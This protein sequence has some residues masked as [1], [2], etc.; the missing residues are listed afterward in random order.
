MTTPVAAVSP[1]SCF[2]S[3]D[4]KRKKK[5]SGAGRRINAEGTMWWIDPARRSVRME[6]AAHAAELERWKAGG[7]SDD[8][9]G[10]G[11]TGGGSGGGRDSRSSV[12]GNSGRSREAD[13]HSSIGGESRRSG[14]SGA[15]TEARRSY[16][17]GGVAAA[18]LRDQ[19]FEDE[20]EEGDDE[21]VDHGAWRAT[22]A[23][24]RRRA[25]DHVTPLAAPIVIVAGTNAAKDGDGI[26]GGAPPTA[27]QILFLRR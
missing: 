21:R 22:A 24:T 25:T 8:G 20:E 6:R 10:S 16:A 13:L 15:A 1:S 26:G 27:S 5:G 7:G 4:K 12:G 11:R 3:V 23:A 2:S 14:G 18:I 17:E 19:E 9:G